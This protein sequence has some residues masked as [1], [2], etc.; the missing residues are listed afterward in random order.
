[1][2]LTCGCLKPHE[3]HGKEDY[4]T[5][6]QFEKSAGLDNLGLDAAVENLKKTVEIAKKEGQHA[7]R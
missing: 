1:M 6:E 5:I 2:C 4:L 7:H 3:N